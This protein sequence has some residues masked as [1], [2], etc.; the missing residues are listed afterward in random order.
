MN[1]IAIIGLSCLFPDAQT[2]EQYWQNLLRKQDSTSLA[3]EQQMGVDA[4]V[5]YTNQKG[6]TDKYY[7]LK[8]GYIKDFKFDTKGYQI[9]PDILENLDQLY[10]WSIYVAKEALKDSGYLDNFAVLKS[11]FENCQKFYHY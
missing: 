9:A 5:F 8:G 3:T 10:Q 6:I 11:N 7:C 4:N 1:K 2:P